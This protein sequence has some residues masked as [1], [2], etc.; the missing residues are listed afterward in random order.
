M[1]VNRSLLILNLTLVSILSAQYELDRTAVENL[2]NLTTPPTVYQVDTSQGHSDPSETVDTI[3]PGDLKHIFFDSVDY[4]GNE[5][6]VYSWIS[7]PANASSTNKVPAIVVIHG[8]GGKAFKA[9][10][11][12]W[13]KIG[14]A[15]ISI[16]TEGHSTLDGEFTSPTTNHSYSG[17]SRTG[18]YDTYDDPIGDQFMYHATAG[19][20]LANSLLRSLDF[21]D[22][23][24]IGVHG[25]SWGGV[26]TSTAIGIDQRFDFAIPAYGCGHMWDA[27]GS[28]QTQ[29]GDIEYY[30]NVWD[31][32]LRLQNAT[33]PIQ[34]LSWSNDSP[35][36]I[37]SQANS[38]NK[39]PSTEMVSL[40]QG[41]Q[42]GHQSAWLR[43]DPYDFAHSVVTTGSSWC[44]EQNITTNGNQVEVVFSSTKTL[45]EAVLIY[46]NEM[47]RTTDMG[48]TDTNG[49]KI[50]FEQTVDS[51]TETSPGIWTVTAT[52]PPNVTGWFINVAADTSFPTDFTR[53]G[54]AI[55]A[56]SRLQDVV[57]ITAPRTMAFGLTDEGES[58]L[59]RTS[60]DITFTALNNL[61]VSSIAIVNESHVGAFTCT[62]EFASSATYDTIGFN[63][64][65]SYDVTFDNTVAGLALGERATATLQ[66]TWIEFDNV[67]TNTIDI[68]L[69]AEI[70]AP[71]NIIYD[72]SANWSSKSP[73]IADLVYIRDGAIVTLD[74]D[75][76]I[77]ELIVGFN[78]TGGSLVID[79]DY[80]FEVTDNI[81]IETGAELII[82]DGIVTTNGLDIES[83]G[84]VTVSGGILEI[85]DSA[86]DFDGELCVEGG[87][88]NI[89]ENNIDGSGKI[90]ITNGA[91]NFDS[92]TS[93]DIAEIEISGGSLNFNTTN[94]NNQLQIGEHGTTV[95][96]I[97]GSAPTVT[98]RI[99]Q[100]QANTVTNPIVNF[101]LD[102]AGASPIQASSFMNLPELTMNVDG[103]SYTGG[104]GE[105]ILLEA[106][107]LATI[108]DLNKYVTTGFVENGLSA[109]FVQD[110]S[111]NV[112]KII[113]TR[114]AYGIW[115]DAE[116]LPVSQLAADLDPD[117]DGIENIFEY[118][119]DTNPLTV[120]QP[121]FP[122]IESGLTF[123][124]NRNTSA[125]ENVD[126]VF[127]YSTDLM[128]WTDVTVE[129]SNPD[130]EISDGTV[131][132]TEDVMIELNTINGATPKKF[133]RLK[134]QLT[135]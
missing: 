117:T 44:E 96:T 47:G 115:A 110:Q 85:S 73:T 7:I 69:E 88:V 39:A 91:V 33:M 17:P 26:I 77:S 18:V 41:M 99:F 24:H 3:S 1:N 31:P 121:S 83:G 66:I 122:S 37:D 82:S 67:T 132:G 58:V 14:Y 116:S 93:V 20:I 28:W 46:A 55:Y 48:T 95:V 16:D 70:F 10:V 15:A 79:Q 32:M 38:Y 75:E 6:R 127:Q 51:F 78:D 11:E 120:N 86:F 84:K 130:I 105:V 108:G 72:T 23:D 103:S 60:D 126:Q 21:I 49:N 61:E 107:N 111:E 34:W 128:N 56:S 101:K 94:S 76:V 125:S 123:N 119:F 9:W 87:V 113:L 106:A 133:G 27:V 8:G 90:T 45:N 53:G 4:E 57:N 81:L 54:G 22:T 40:I 71:Q 30:R 129:N 36:N 62:D 100:M 134:V 98:T 35:F 64:G 131:T 114:N 74:Q 13:N 89:H 5:T 50:W 2:A 92:A 80:T 109:A 135:Q 52:L 102:S 124:Y 19:T 63:T 118:L 112:V 43:P 68:P 59:T 25:I 65:T 42:H 97:I 104:E 12:Q 29:I